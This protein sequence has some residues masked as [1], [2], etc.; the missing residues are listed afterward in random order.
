MLTL[1]LP[2]VLALAGGEQVIAFT[3]RRAAGEGDE[4]A[5]VAS[6]TRN[7]SEL[8]PAYRHWAGRSAPDG[9]WTA[10]VMAVHPAAGLDAEAGAARH[11]LAAAP[12]D[13]D[14]LVLRVHRPDGEP[15]LSD[16]AFAA[17][18][19]SVEAALQ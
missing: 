17:R 12:T 3:P 16:T 10:I 2:D 14:L 7:V 13:G 8:K 15:V 6:G 11:V 5:L 1:P 4:V 9:E 18:V 19:R